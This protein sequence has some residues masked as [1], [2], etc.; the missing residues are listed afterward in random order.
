[1]KVK[2]NYI[3]EEKGENNEWLAKA[4]EKIYD[5]FVKH[6][7]GF[8]LIPCADTDDAESVDNANLGTCVTNCTNPFMFAIAMAGAIS[9]FSITSNN[10]NKDGQASRA[11][12]KAISDIVNQIIEKEKDEQ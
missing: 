5:D 6:K 3:G 10:G 9:S 2:A 8:I 11:L 1:M 4:A 12:L 7:Q